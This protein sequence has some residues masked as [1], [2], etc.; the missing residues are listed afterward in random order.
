[1]AKL[2]PAEH[3][4]LAQAVD[5]LRAGTAARFELVVVPLSDRYVLYPVAFGAFAALLVGG[6]IAVFDA[7]L[8]A[9]IVF[10]TEAVLFVALSAL[11]EWPPLKL[12]LVP[13]HLKHERA[14]QFAHRAFA[15]RV[16]A[17]RERKTGMVFFVSL[18]E[19]Y[20]ELVTDDALDRHVGQPRWNEIVADCTEAARKGRLAEGLVQAIEAC[21]RELARHFPPPG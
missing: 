20:V 14:R 12:L 17:A 2:S 4:R 21:G 18:G 19:R 11:L 9:Q 1:M 13:K 6:L 7:R 5:A 3:K 15:A 16:L 8:S 10:G